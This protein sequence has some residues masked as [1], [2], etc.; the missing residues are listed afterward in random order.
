[1][2]KVK[3]IFELCFT[4]WGNTSNEQLLRVLSLRVQKRPGCGRSPTARAWLQTSKNI[5]EMDY[6]WTTTENYR[7]SFQ[8]K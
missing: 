3:P 8:I 5:Y 4:V 6:D 7:E 1:M 2:H